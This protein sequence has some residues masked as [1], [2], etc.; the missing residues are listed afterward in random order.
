MQVQFLNRYKSA[1]KQPRFFHLRKS[2][3]LIQVD[4]QPEMFD[5]IK[6][7]EEYGSIIASMLRFETE[8]LI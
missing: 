1:I 4:P 8:T 6:L 3:V 7:K 2:Y 5:A